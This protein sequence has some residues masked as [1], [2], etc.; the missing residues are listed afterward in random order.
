MADIQVEALIN[1]SWHRVLA[2]TP[3]PYRREKIVTFE[4]AQANDPLYEDV[5]KPKLED[6]IAGES[7]FWVTVGDGETVLLGTGTGLF[8]VAHVY[9]SAPGIH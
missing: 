1:G 6:A 2:I 7:E 4:V 8:R 3:V 9:G 5:L